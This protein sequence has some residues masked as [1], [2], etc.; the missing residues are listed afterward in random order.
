[1]TFCTCGH[2]PSDHHMDYGRCEADEET[3]W[4]PTP[5]GCP[6]FEADADE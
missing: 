5:C 4:G 3:L 1:M 6:H 2:K